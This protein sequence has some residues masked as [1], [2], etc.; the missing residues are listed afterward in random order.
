M[1][2]T[3]SSV[4]PPPLHNTVF[5]HRP[6]R[7]LEPRDIAFAKVDVEGYD[8]QAFFGLQRILQ[9]GHVPFLTIEY[10]SRMAN[11]QARCDAVKFMRHMHTIG[12]R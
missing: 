2:T 3:N 1:F 11:E 10:N 12:Y 6:R 7:L 5:L 8:T 9:E 4:D